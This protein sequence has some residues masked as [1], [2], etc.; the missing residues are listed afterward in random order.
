MQWLGERGFADFGALF[1]SQRKK[2]VTDADYATESV[3]LANEY[4]GHLERRLKSAAYS[5]ALS[6]SVPDAQYNSQVRCGRSRA[7]PFPEA[8]TFS[9]WQVP[10]L[11]KEVR[12]AKAKLVASERQV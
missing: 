12:E 10:L 6:R 9:I 8:S 5:S 11:Q 3:L 4:Q 2:S 1:P 7:P